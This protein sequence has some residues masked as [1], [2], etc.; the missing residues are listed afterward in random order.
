VRR[1]R[2]ANGSQISFIEPFC[3]R[4]PSR[5]IEWRLFVYREDW[6]RKPNHKEGEMKRFSVA[7][8]LAVVLGFSTLAHAALVDRGGGLIYDTDLNITW[9]QSPNNT[10][11]NLAQAEAWATT[12]SYYDS[13]RDQTLTGWRLPTAVYGAYVYGTDGTTTGGYN[14][15]TS[16]MGHLYYTE[17]G[18]KG[19]YDVSGNVQ[20]DYG[21]STNSP[22]SNLQPYYYWT[23]TA[24]QNS[25]GHYWVFNF[26]DG[27]QLAAVANGT[28][29]GGNGYY[30]L[31]VRSGDV[32]ASTVPIPGAVWL[33]GSGLIGLIGIRRKFKK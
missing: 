14:I 17:L 4:Q 13:V 18:N 21:L 5:Q 23:D 28:D 27:N 20:S 31:A 8:L 19:Y 33:L 26:T 3:R 1:G 29:F 25:A 22:F 30:A 24:V 10:F 12:L 32:V 2:K 6:Y 15:T 7:F 9:L 16:E 11:M